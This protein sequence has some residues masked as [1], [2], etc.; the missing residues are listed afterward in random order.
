MQDI[1]EIEYVK[2]AKK[3]LARSGKCMKKS[4]PELLL[5]ICSHSPIS[6]MKDKLYSLFIKSY[7]VIKQK[8]TSIGIP[9]PYHCHVSRNFYE[10]FFHQGSGYLD[11]GSGLIFHADWTLVLR[12]SHSI[13]VV[14]QGL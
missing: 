5:R 11:N 8:T 1:V 12:I 14:R 6:F 13:H 4:V 10:I 9:E 3:Q 2:D 7:H